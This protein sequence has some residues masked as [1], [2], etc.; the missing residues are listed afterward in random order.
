MK[1]KT[2]DEIVHAII[3][4]QK[5]CQEISEAEFN[6]VTVNI[7]RENC[8]K[9]DKTNKKFLTEVFKLIHDNIY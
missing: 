7:I 4:L 6:N 1:Q 5:K 8:P 2:P 3:E 9:E